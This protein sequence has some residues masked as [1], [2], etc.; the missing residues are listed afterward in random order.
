MEHQRTE[1]RSRKKEEKKKKNKK[2]K[3]RRRRK[4]GSHVLPRRLDF[5]EERVAR[6]LVA[7]VRVAVVREREAQPPADR[8]AVRGEARR[9]VGRDGVLHHD[10]S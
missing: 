4:N 10:T 6:A 3:R 8:A 9:R 2:E 1:N 7:H 5:A